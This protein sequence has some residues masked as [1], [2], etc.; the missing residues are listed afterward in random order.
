MSEAAMPPTGPLANVRQLVAQ[1]AAAPNHQNTYTQL[2][3]ALT[4]LELKDLAAVYPDGQAPSTYE[5]LVALG[6][7]EY[8]AGRFPSAAEIYAQATQLQPDWPFAE[9]SRAYALSTLGRHSEADAIFQRLARRYAWP[10]GNLRLGEPF[11]QELLTAPTPTVRFELLHKANRP[12]AKWQALVAVDSRYLQRYIPALARSFLQ[13]HGDEADLHVHIVNPT[14]AALQLADELAAAANGGLAISGETVDLGEDRL[15]NCDYVREGRSYYACSRFLLAPTLLADSNRPLV[16][17][18]ADLV[19]K[20]SLSA[21]VAA[22]GDWDVGLTR[23]SIRSQPLWQQYFASFQV[24]RP[25]AGGTAFTTLLAKYLRRFLDLDRWIWPLD[26]AGLYSLG[27]FVNV[28][29]EPKSTRILRIS[30][31]I[32]TSGVYFENLVG[33]MSRHDRPT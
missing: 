8:G 3:V 27:E 23:F 15:S 14:A 32:I 25:T 18:D 5:N 26:Q 13:H 28:Q 4:M 16:I 30:P 2:W 10:Y 1:F 9:G 29:P 17:F 19:V 31:T 12:T 7:H 20:Q 33:S 22:D 11:W 6:N 21:L 24:F